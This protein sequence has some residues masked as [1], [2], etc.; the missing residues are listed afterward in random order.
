MHRRSLE[1][2]TANK[3]KHI[4][5]AGDFNCPDIDWDCLSV[6]KEAQDKEAQQ[7]IIDLSVDFNLPQVQD[8]PTREDNIL[9]L[10]FTTNPSLIKSTSN[11]P[12]ISDHDI[13]VVDSDTKPFYA[14]QKP[15]KSFVFSKANW[16]QLKINIT[17]LSAEIVRLY[18]SGSSV[19]HLWDIFKKD[20]M[21]AINAN[22]PTQLKTSG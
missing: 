21:I 3:E 17:E 18:R 6:Q 16:E 8:K 4:V 9:D 15:R 12:G 2:V 10:V 11:T 22:I 5:I 1:L 13:V 19:Q 7:A 20:L 14:K